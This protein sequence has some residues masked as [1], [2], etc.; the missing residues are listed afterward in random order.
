[1]K[2]V[3]RG[4]KNRVD[5][6]IARCLCERGRQGEAMPRGKISGLHR[7]AHHA[8]DKADAV[9]R[10]LDC[11]DKR[12]TPASETANGGVAHGCPDFNSSPTLPAKIFSPS[13]PRARP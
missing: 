13:A 3:G 8:A 9:R 1:M 6:G 2:R 10:A 4:K 5:L 11:R 12:L 7:I